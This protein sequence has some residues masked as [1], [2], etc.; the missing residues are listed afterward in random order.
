MKD[1]E[2]NSAT[3]E[4]SKGDMR[5]VT[6]ALDPIEVII[7]EDKIILNEIVF[8]F[9]KHNITEQGAKELDR[10]VGVMQ[11][12]PA[13]VIMVKSHT[14]NRGDDKFN[15]DL[16]NRRAKSTIDYVI[17]KGIDKGRI[18]GK[19]YG[20]SEPKVDCKEEC[21]EEQH[22]ENRRSEFIIIKK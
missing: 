17:S 8:E 6:V 3:V 12:Y 15:M 20:E 13:M 5:K 2:S 7:V 10:L 16:S 18:S 9:N 11:K 4:A 1:Y 21:S 19:G 22:A 14:D